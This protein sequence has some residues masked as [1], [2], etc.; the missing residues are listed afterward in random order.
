[1]YFPALCLFWLGLVCGV[2]FLAT[3]VK[4]QAPSLTLPTALEVGKVTFHLLSKIESALAVLLVVVCFVTVSNMGRYYSMMI[5]SGLCLL[6]VLQLFWLRPV[7][8]ERLELIV[9]GIEV[10][11]SF[12]HSWYIGLEV[13]KVLLLLIGAL[14]LF[15]K[16]HS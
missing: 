5:T 11:P 12:H 16:P 10:S 4:F 2:S 15:W 8:D 9:K 1:M 7:L 13:I 6:V 14:G 3:P